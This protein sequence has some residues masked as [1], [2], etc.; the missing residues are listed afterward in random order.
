MG[1][2]TLVTHSFDCIFCAR[3]WAIQLPQGAE[4]NILNKELYC[5]WCGNKT[6][7]LTDD[8]FRG[9]RHAEAKS[10]IE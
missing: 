2:N 5:P 9:H 3:Y 8:Y 7:Y 4:H 1:Y 10:E 6:A